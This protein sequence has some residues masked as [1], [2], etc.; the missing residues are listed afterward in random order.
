MKYLRRIPCA[1]LMALMVFAAVLSDDD[2]EGT[3][4]ING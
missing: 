3:D 2:S 4:V 1:L